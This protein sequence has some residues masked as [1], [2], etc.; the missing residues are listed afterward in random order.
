MRRSIEGIEMQTLFGRNVRRFWKLACISATLFTTI[1]QLSSYYDGTYVTVVEYKKFNERK[2]DIYPSIGICF[3][4]TLREEKLESYGLDSKTYAD[5][6]FGTGKSWNR[7]LLEIDYDS[8]AQDLGEY[9]LSYG[10]KTADWKIHNRYV[11]GKEKDAELE[12]KPGKDAKLEVK[13]GFTQYRML[14]INCM[15]IHS[16]ILK[17][18]QIYGFYVH[19]SE[20]I[21]NGG[22]RVDNPSEDII[23]ENQLWVIPHY[24]RQLLRSATFT[25]RRWPA[26]KFKPKTYIMAFDIQ[27]LDVV[28]QLNTHSRPCLEK[29]KDY[30]KAFRQSILETLGCK[31]PYWNSSSLLPLCSTKE[32]LNYAANRIK[33]ALAMDSLHSTHY[34][35][36][37]KPCRRFKNIVYS[38]EDIETT[39]ESS[40]AS[41]RM[42]FDYKFPDYKELK[43]VKLMDFQTFV[44]NLMLYTT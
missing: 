14:G 16:P 25:K 13:P 20:G 3:T 33:D 36:G 31:P 26:R 10:Y 9:I 42:V 22:E 15:T 21:F 19:L 35:H 1:W 32:K 8:V 34:N 30:D 37:L 18:I 23:H 27:S 39:N 7:T 6:L 44:G 28:Q 11:K 38:Y 12:K 41:V 24:P 40:T 29:L 2:G 5:F 43:G 4:N 17:N